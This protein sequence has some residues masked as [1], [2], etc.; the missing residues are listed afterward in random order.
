MCRSPAC[1]G[2]W[3]RI[4]PSRAISRRCGVW[5]TSSCRMA[6]SSEG[7]SGLAP[8]AAPQLLCPHP[9]AGAADPAVLQDPHPAVP[10]QQRG[11]AGGPQRSEEHT[12]ELQSRP[13]LVCRLLLEKKKK[14][15]TTLLPTPTEG[16][17]LP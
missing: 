8:A 14:S 13:H 1:A 15:Q 9:V 4:R 12:S 10:D 2:C 3:N 6:S 11:S 7:R 5:V 17:T 16:L